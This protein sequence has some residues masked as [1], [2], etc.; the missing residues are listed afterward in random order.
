M[1]V[2]AERKTRKG[3][4]FLFVGSSFARR[5]GW[6]H[7]LF[8]PLDSIR[9][10]MSFSA[11]LPSHLLFCNAEGECQRSLSMLYRGCQAYFRA[12]G[13]KRPD[14]HGIYLPTWRRSPSTKEWLM[15]TIMVTGKVLFAS[16]NSTDYSGNTSDMLRFPRWAANYVQLLWLLILQYFYSHFLCG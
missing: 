15:K 7:C 16:R 9:L 8:A 14:K 11:E 13:D 6:R 2:L 10:E 12:A 5:C 3:L 4:F 1:L